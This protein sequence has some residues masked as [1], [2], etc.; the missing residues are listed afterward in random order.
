[1]KL[2]GSNDAINNN[3]NKKNRKI[4]EQKPPEWVEIK[5]QANKQCLKIKKY[6]PLIP[7]NGENLTFTFKTG[8]LFNQKWVTLIK[9]INKSYASEEINN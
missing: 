6:S 9:K 1:M 2:N 5:N 7:I 4:F 8:N 3:N